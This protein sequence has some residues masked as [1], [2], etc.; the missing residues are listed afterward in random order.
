VPSSIT[1]PM[2]TTPMVTLSPSEN[3]VDGQQVQVQMRGFGAEAKVRLSECASLAAANP[4]GCG[5]QLAAQPVMITDDRGSAVITFV[6]R[7]SASSAPLAPASGSCASQCV[8]VATGGA[9]GPF[10]SATLHFS[11]TTITPNLGAD[12]P[13]CHTSQVT[14]REGRG[15]VGAGN[16]LGVYVLA[17][18]SATTCRLFGYPGLQML[19]SNHRPVPTTVTR[20]GAYM[21]PALAPS[22]VILPPG[23]IASFSVG[24]VDV[25][26]GD[27]PPSVQCVPSTYVEITPP[28]ERQPL[29]VSSSIAPCGHGAIIVSPVVSGED[30]VHY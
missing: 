4:G 2:P 23:G 15:G 11:T 30:G 1:V 13:R 25:A 17:N 28:D 3:L 16:I 27:E 5:E 10:A 20:G 14:V 7:S 29:L 12:L 6:V 26:P 22:R 18:T 8:L 19:D 9:N 21:F 24:Y